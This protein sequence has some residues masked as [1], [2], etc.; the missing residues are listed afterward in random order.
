[1]LSDPEYLR[2]LTSNQLF[3]DE[4]SDE[5]VVRS[6][7]KYI[8]AYC[9][10]LKCTEQDILLDDEKYEQVFGIFSNIMSTKA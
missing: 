9:A 4:K 5:P 10:E 2:E 6:F 3:N 8:D 1:M 7:I